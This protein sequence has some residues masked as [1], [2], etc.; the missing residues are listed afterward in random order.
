MT[1][2]GSEKKL[3]PVICL[4]AAGK[5]KEWLFRMRIMALELKGLFRKA[6]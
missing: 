2:S 4:R 3:N 1:P 5:E 6:I